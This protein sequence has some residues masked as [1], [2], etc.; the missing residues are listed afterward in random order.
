MLPTRKLGQFTVSSVGLGCMNL[1]HAYGRPL[2][3]EAA[4]ALLLRALDLG[5]T[6]FDTAALYGFGANEQ[7]I[8]KVLSPH[9]SRFTLASKGGAFGLVSDSGTRR[10]IDGRPTT[11]RANC[12]QSLRNLKT[13][14]IDLYYLHRWDKKVPIEE[15]IGELA[16]LAKEGKVGQI[17]LSEISADTLRRAHAVHPI[18]AVQ[19]EYSIV[20]RN[21][22]LRVIRVCEEIGASFVAFSP[23]G[24]GMLS[25]EPLPVDSLEPKDIRRA[26]P[27]F[28]AANYAANYRLLSSVRDFAQMVGITSSQLALAWLLHQGPH[29]VVIPGT[30]TISHLEENLRAAAIELDTPT[31]QRFNDVIDALR[32]RGNRYSEATRAEVD[33]E[34]WPNDGSESA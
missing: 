28:E 5:I 21:P 16:K 24:R 32:L 15:S 7:L 6:H 13:D 1:S 22:E 27:R 3:E 14:V 30:A 33:S 31:L 18:A 8:G 34:E 2:S 20:T 11:L 25:A 17:G 12:E 4:A 29:I 10:V 19:S 23:L 9:R 26:M